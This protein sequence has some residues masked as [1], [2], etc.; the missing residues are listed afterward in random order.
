MT[1]G[2]VGSGYLGSRI[3][4]RLTDFGFKALLACDGRAVENEKVERRY[5][6]LMPGAV[7]QG[8]PYTECVRRHLEAKEHKGFTPLAGDFT[9]EGRLAELVAG[10]DFVVAAL[11]LLSPG[12]LHTI[13][14]LALE[15]GKPWMIL[16]LDGSEA[17][18]G[19]IFKPLETCCYSEFEIQHEAASVGRKDEYL[20]YKESLADGLNNMHLVLPPYLDTA[21]GMGVTGLLH[22]LLSGKS[23]LIGRSVRF[24]FERLSVDYEEVFRLP[25]CP[26]CSPYR[27]YR[28]LFL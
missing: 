27:P 25:R 28:H 4:D 14:K 8:K 23:F 9:D 17:F 16:Y 18:I 13:N 3:I 12:V 26:A 19:P 20:V 5:F 24:D 22:F 21:S 6:N 7:E 1:V 10:S 2:I 11:E 15:A